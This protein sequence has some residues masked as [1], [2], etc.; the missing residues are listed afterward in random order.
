MFEHNKL[1]SASDILQPAG[2][3]IQLWVDY[4]PSCCSDF[5]IEEGCYQWLELWIMIL[6]P[7]SQP[8]P[9]FCFS[10]WQEMQS[11]A[12]LGFSTLLSFLFTYLF[13]LS[14]YLL[15]SINC[16]FRKSNCASVIESNSK[17]F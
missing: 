13:I 7:G 11:N 16:V 4:T 2:I 6:S 9:F 12:P 8:L 15:S 10:G 14:F 3:R 1:F 17:S 5:G